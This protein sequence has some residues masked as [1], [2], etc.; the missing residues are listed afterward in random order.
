M[1]SS[2][3]T[4]LQKLSKYKVNYTELHRPTA[5][6]IKLASFVLKNFISAILQIGLT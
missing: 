3:Q 2:P 4:V 1:L 5:S 6:A